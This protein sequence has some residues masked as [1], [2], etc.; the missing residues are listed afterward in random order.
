M[1]GCGCGYSF[2]HWV[3]SW[4]N[5]VLDW[6]FTAISAMGMEEFYLL[7]IPLIYWCV[8]KSLGARLC[9]LFLFGILLN[10]WVKHFYSRPR[11]DPSRVRVLFKQSGTGP[12]YPSG[13]AQGSF[14][15][16]GYC[17]V[18]ARTA[19]FSLF[20]AVFVFLMC[21]SRL[22]LGLHFPIDLL[23][24]LLSGLGS[25]L[26]FLVLLL[27]YEKIKK[28]ISWPAWLVVIVLTLAT[29]VV[30]FP[31]K[32]FAS[33][34]GIYLGFFAGVV[35][36][37][38]FVGFKANGTFAEQVKKVILGLAVGAFLIS[39]EAP[40]FISYGLASAW[41]GFGAPWC[42]KKMGWA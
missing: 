33:I 37:K 13:H 29:F 18:Q 26:F 4:Q 36:E 25:L 41:V 38:R 10:T 17:A 12:A 21:V 16:W 23:G 15:F 3:Q 9:F 27:L 31:E 35:L 11:P 22:Y 30:L 42:F 20:C 8:N 19:W 24:G 1:D 34:L 32:R 39:F 40:L 14:A 6:L 5:P 7:A 28:Y 2:I